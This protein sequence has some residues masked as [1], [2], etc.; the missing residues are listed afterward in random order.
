[1]H[2]HQ[3]TLEQHSSLQHPFQPVAVPLHHKGMHSHRQQRQL[4]AA[5]SSGCGCTHAGTGTVSP[6]TVMLR[7][8][9][10]HS[11]AGQGF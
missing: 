11:P 3:A 8:T 1:M 9:L 6:H 4:C 7:V 10:L 5:N 2:L